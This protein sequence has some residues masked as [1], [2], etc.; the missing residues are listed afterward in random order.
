[1]DPLYSFAWRFV[2]A[3][4]VTVELS[5]L[6]FA[7]AF[8]LG[9]A[10]TVMAI[11]PLAPLRWFAATYIEI[12]RM[13]PL[14]ALLLLFVF[15]LPKLGFM[16]SLTTSSVLVLGFYTAAWIAEVLRAGVNAVPSGQIEAARSIGMRFM[17]VVGNVVIPQAV[18]T[19]IPPLGNLFVNQIK[20]S[21]I[22][23]AVGVFDITYTAQRINFET[24]Q[25]VPTFAA[26]L[27]A[28]MALTVPLGLLMRRIEHN[29]AV[30]R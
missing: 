5:L 9:V 11:G 21:S 14:L 15:G 30:T 6:S 29:M 27:L 16:Y 13:T 17:Q 8:A 20:A 28:Y 22:A 18:R 24:A 10:L 7:M 12:M 26:A 25:A 23:A 4:G 1:M 3:M 2:E 19:V